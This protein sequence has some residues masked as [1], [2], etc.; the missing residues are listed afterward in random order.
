MGIFDYIK[1]QTRNGCEMPIF[2]L[3]DLNIGSEFDYNF[4]SWQVAQCYDYEWHD[5]S[6]SLEYEVN[7]GKDCGTMYVDIE[8]GFIRFVS[9][10]NM[11]LIAD[12]TFN[13][14]KNYN[15]P[16]RLIT[17]NNK[18]FLFNQELIG[19]CFEKNKEIGRDL[20]VWDYIDESNRFSLSIELW[21]YDYFEVYMG[22]ILND[23]EIS[24]ISA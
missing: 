21:S 3:S 4:S 2:Q 1:K 23:F 19:A 17:I 6:Q 18:N 15:N 13:E 22:K 10:I 11:D 12:D 7:N 5:G 14:I 8:N 24:N 16:P 20:I 9:R